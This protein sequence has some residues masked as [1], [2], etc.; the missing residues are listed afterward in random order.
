L[1]GANVLDAKQHLAAIVESSDD[2]IISK[3]LNGI[4]A[5]WN[6]A[7]ERLFGYRPDEALG[8]PITLIIPAERYDEEAE[9][10]AKI[11]KG[12]RI[13]H[14]ETERQCKDGRM[15]E[16]SLSVSPVKDSEGRIVGASKIVRDISDRRRSEK[17]RDLLL[18]EMKHRAKNFA[19]IIDAIARQ[20][21]PKNNPKAA[22]LLDTFVG[23]LRVLMMSGGI[24]VESAERTASIGGLFQSVL[25]PFENPNGG[26]TIALSGPEIDVSEQTAGGLALAVHELATNA[27]K[28]GALK[29]PD[30]RVSLAWTLEPAGL[31]RIEWKETAAVPVPA[32]PSRV[33]FG[34]R[35]I[36]SALSHDRDA[37]TVL[38]FEPD[39]VRCV[40]VF[41]VH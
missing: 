3:D 28:Y 15:V 20:S 17:Q 13:E 25:S 37:T 35:V 22:A 30:G 9:I 10:I 18:G 23:R 7:A 34:S 5:S 4:I 39:G 11:R 41:R 24:I 29:W 27:L 14:F 16:V 38:S 1:K 6:R 19:A 2:A 8:Q 26:S 32:E 36:R 33:G 12:E 21:R 31:V 40:L